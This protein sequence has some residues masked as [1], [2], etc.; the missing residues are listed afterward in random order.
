M[1]P[2]YWYSSVEY[3]LVSRRYCSKIILYRFTALCTIFVC[4]EWSPDCTYVDMALFQTVLLATCNRGAYRYSTRVIRSGDYSLPTAPY[5]L[6]YTVVI[7]LVI[8]TGM[9]LG[10]IVKTRRYNVRIE[11]EEEIKWLDLLFNLYGCL[12][13]ILVQFSSGSLQNGCKLKTV[14][15]NRRVG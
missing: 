13:E 4:Y 11:T 1:C 10:A 8:N 9:Y 15:K 5:I 7:V 6:R 12:C 3:M 2:F 14:D